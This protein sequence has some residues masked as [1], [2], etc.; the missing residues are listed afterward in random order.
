MLTFTPTSRVLLN[1]ILKHPT[2]LQARKL[3]KKT[4]T[5]ITKLDAQNVYDTLGGVLI[6]TLSIYST[7]KFC[8][9]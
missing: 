5:N 2:F 8:E 3:N 4:S 9:R 7:S 1:E 6:I